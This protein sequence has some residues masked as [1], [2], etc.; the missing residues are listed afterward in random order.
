MRPLP[1]QAL[2]VDGC[3][4]R[5]LA[6][7]LVQHGLRE[8]RLVDLVVSHAAVA[9]HVDDAVL[10]KLRAWHMSTDDDDEGKEEGE[11]AEGRKRGTLRLQNR[12]APCPTD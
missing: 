11:R 10:A 8:E 1:H 12:N 3:G 9:D 7:L 4:V 6:D 2:L 5:V